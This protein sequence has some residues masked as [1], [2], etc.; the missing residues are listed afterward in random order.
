LQLYAFLDLPVEAPRDINAFRVSR[1]DVGSHPEHRGALRM[2]AVLENT[3]RHAQP[4]PELYVDM[5]D[6]W[7]ETV[8]ARYFTPIEYL[9]DPTATERPSAAG[10]RA[11][12]ELAIVDPAGEA[13]GFQ[14]RPCFRNGE[15]FVCPDNASR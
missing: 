11:A 8:G 15:R 10:N 5:Q 3:G 13:V 4:W 2:T 1:T 7:G 6:R 9:R 14:I 12:V